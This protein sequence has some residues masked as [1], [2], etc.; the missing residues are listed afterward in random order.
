MQEQLRAC[1]MRLKDRRNGERANLKDKISVIGGLKF[2][3]KVEKP[4]VRPATGKAAEM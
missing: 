3:Q 4:P 1:D 2:V